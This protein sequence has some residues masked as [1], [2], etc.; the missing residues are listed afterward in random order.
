MILAA[1]VGI[2]VCGAATGISWIKIAYE[3]EQRMRQQMEWKLGVEKRQTQLGKIR[4]TFAATPPG[5]FLGRLL[6]DAH[7]AYEPLDVT[8]LFLTGWASLVYLCQALLGLVPINAAVTSTATV[9]IVARV[10]LGSRRGWFI[11][12]LSQQLPEVA[13]IL[14]NA[15]RA[16]LTVPQGLAL[17]TRELPNPAGAVFGTISA[18][19]NLNQPLQQTLADAQTQFAES[20]EMRLLI[21]TILTHHRSGGNLAKA[22]DVLAHTLAERKGINEEILSATA[23]ARSSAVI[24]PVM[25]ILCT[26]MMNAAI[27]GYLN[28]LFTVWG[29]VILIPVLFLQW[30]AY[31]IIRQLSDIQ[32]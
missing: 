17:V 19:L 21:L 22:L 16:G 23:G 11:K 28:Q 5:R 7:L 26:A 27:P 2:A 14:A 4:Q 15:V 20:R 25:P 29:L 3:A 32:V 30:L 8:A 31:A 1:I 18:Q 6:R 24:L 9:L 13:W 10:I 12:T